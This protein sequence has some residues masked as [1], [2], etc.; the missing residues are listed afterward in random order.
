MVTQK[1]PKKEE[2][3]EKALKATVLS[4]RRG[5]HTQK[6]NQFVLEIPGC[7]TKAKAAKFI[8]R[9]VV[10]TAPGARGKKISGKITAPHGNSGSLRARFNK[11][12]PGT[13][14]AK[15]VEVF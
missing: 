8:G 4:Y 10:W 9:K 2:K 14:L 13:V 6:T 7:D 3:P 1:A 12:L 5:R 11:G 15:K